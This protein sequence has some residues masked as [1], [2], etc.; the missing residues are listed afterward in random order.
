MT[1]TD[2]Y[3]F[4]SLFFWALVSAIQL[5]TLRWDFPS[6]FKNMEWSIQNDE[7]LAVTDAR[8]LYL[9]NTLGTKLTDTHPW[10]VSAAFG[11]GSPVMIYIGFILFGFNNTG[12][13][14]FHCG[15]GI[16]TN[17]LV[18]L[19]TLRILPGPPGAALA[20]LFITSANMFHLSRYAI[21]EHMLNLYIAAGIFVIAF[22]GPGFLMEHGFLFSFLMAS[23]VLIKIN[24][25]VYLG[26]LIVLANI[27]WF[28]GFESLL[29]SASGFCVGLLLFEGLQWL[30]LLKVGVLKL[31]AENFYI[32]V[33]AHAGYKNE[34]FYDL[35]PEPR[36][37]LS[38]TIQ[39]FFHLFL[40]AK[41][42]RDATAN[43]SLLTVCALCFCAKDFSRF[44][45]FLLAFAATGLAISAPLFWYYKRSMFLLLILCFLTASV[46]GDTIKTPEAGI[47]AAFFIGGV[48]LARLFPLW[49]ERHCLK[50]NSIAKKEAEQLETLTEPDSIIGTYTIPA[51]FLWQ[52]HRRML[53]WEDGLFTN[54]EM[55]AAAAE[56]R[57]DYMMLS[58]SLDSAMLEKS[59]LTRITVLK[60]S[61]EASDTPGNAYLY[62]FAKNRKKA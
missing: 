19:F 36:A 28:S 43:I 55:I 3:L 20:L 21:V 44:S 53:W 42:Y 39:Y 35:P 1:I 60:I 30:L 25:P 2:P 29:K 32:T 5:A 58:D 13:R 31:R 22:A 14:F 11:V 62:K 54:E 27:F 12:L 41:L 7:K 34:C 18:V 49:R 61:E 50:L 40:S 33:K 8:N 57:A 52:T 37:V 56:K 10:P 24:F 59:A 23:C 46:L 4:V 26:I 6:V 9:K 45:L 15:A 38:K 48:F 47:A 16:L 17:L 51:R